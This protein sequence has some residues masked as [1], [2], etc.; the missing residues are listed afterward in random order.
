MTTSGES[1]KKKKKKS[2]QR[3]QQALEHFVY[4]QFIATIASTSETK[5]HSIRAVRRF[6]TTVR[7]FVLGEISSMRIIH[8]EES[9]SL[10]TFGNDDGL[11]G[12]HITILPPPTAQASSHIRIIKSFYTFIYINQ[13]R[14]QRT[15][16]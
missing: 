7:S 14:C 13:R 4:I 8:V 5:L 2:Q 3:Q 11:S 16:Q 12:H 10:A 15:K 9:K 1:K 6:T